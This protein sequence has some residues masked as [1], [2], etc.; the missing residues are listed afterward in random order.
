MGMVGRSERVLHERQREL[1][2]VNSFQE[3]GLRL[4]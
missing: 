4:R 1:A 3:T 2:R